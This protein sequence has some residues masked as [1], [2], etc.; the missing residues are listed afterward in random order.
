MTALAIYR[1]LLRRASLPA[2]TLYGPAAG[3]PRLELSGA[4]LANHAA[5][6]AN[7][8]ADEV[9]IDPGT[10][11]TLD[12]PSHWR[13]LTWGLG[14]LLAGAHVGDGG[15]TVVTSDPGAAGENVIAVSLGALDLSWPG[16]LPAMVLDGNADVLGQADILLDESLGADS[17]A[18]ELVE[19]IEAPGRRLLV[20]DPSPGRLLAVFLGAMLE[21][22][23]LVVTDAQSYDRALAA[24]G[25]EP[26]PL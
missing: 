4:V 26:Y 21:R 6:A 11:L 17:N 2:L 3:A 19:Q 20:V 15:D 16:D 14:G 18:E 22:R 12:L 25:A 7:L 23:S 24:E 8:L 13:L 5:K 10:R 1:E 9:M